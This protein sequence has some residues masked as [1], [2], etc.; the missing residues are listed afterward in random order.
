MVPFSFDMS[1]VFWST[2]FICDLL[3]FRWFVAK[4]ISDVFRFPPWQSDAPIFWQN[5][6]SCSKWQNSHHPFQQETLAISP[7]VISPWKSGIFSGLH[8]FLA[9]YTNQCQQFQFSKW[10]KHIGFLEVIRPNIF[11]PACFWENKGSF[12]ASCW[13]NKNA[14]LNCIFLWRSNLHFSIL[15]G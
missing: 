12:W 15:Q 8:I 4:Y 13:K 6:P 7:S 5:L 10:K 2:V 11:F 9:N 14:N 1:L 3:E